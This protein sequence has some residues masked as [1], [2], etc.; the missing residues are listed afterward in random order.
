MSFCVPANAA[1]VMI[2]GRQ[3]KT[4]SKDFDSCDVS[5]EG[6]ELLIEASSQYDELLNGLRTVFGAIIYLV[7][8]FKPSFQSAVTGLSVDPKMLVEDERLA[9]T[10]SH[11][12][13]DGGE[14]VRT[15]EAEGWTETAMLRYLAEH[16]ELF[17]GQD[18]E[19]NMKL[20]QSFLKS[21]CGTLTVTLI[22]EPAASLC[23]HW[24]GLIPLEMVG[25]DYCQSHVLF[26]DDRGRLIE[27]Y[28]FMPETIDPA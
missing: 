26:W 9:L 3:S 27:C 18:V 12:K 23:L 14:W 11:H 21:S 20:F 13:I 15:K 24:A 1:R 4:I 25:L 22:H 2:L 5:K 7:S 16:P 28:K 19:K 10:F 6:K 8:P 17:A